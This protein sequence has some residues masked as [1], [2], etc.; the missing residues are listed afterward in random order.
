MAEGGQG[1]VTEGGQGRVLVAD[2]SGV[3]RNTLKILLESLGLREVAYVGGGLDAVREVRDGSYRL[4]FLDGGLWVRDDQPLLRMIRQI[5]AGRKG[6]LHVIMV[7]PEAD[8]AGR[9]RALAEGADD[10]IGKPIAPQALIPRLMGMPG[11]WA[12]RRP[13]PLALPDRGLSRVPTLT[14]G[15]R[16]HYPR[17]G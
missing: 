10:S 9:L 4:L 17:F 13:A 6:Q 12:A 2:G 8:G 5:P 15:T 11:V 14:T 16:G 1:R 3:I 7:L